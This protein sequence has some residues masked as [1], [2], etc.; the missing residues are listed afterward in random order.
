MPCSCRTKDWLF[1]LPAYSC[2]ALHR[3]EQDPGAPCSSARD[4]RVGGDP[5]L[6]GLVD[7]IWHGIGVLVIHQQVESSV[8]GIIIPTGTVAQLIL[9]RCVTSEEPFTTLIMTF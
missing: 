6:V 3:A 4:P 8:P 1:P 9:Y 5:L 2:K 7:V